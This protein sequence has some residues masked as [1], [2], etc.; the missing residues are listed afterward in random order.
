MRV[1]QV[2]LASVACIAALI[3]TPLNA[4]LHNGPTGREHPQTR[5]PQEHYTPVPTGNAARLAASQDVL[6]QPL[7][8]RPRRQE[9]VADAA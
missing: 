5:Y 1:R 3:R 8:V 4:T 6:M 9:R 7:G 2:P